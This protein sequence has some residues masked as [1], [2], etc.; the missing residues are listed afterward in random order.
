[1]QKY[2]DLN[3][4]VSVR[5]AFERNTKKKVLFNLHKI[6]SI[7]APCTNCNCLINTHKVCKAITLQGKI[8]FDLVK[9]GVQNIRNSIRAEQDAPQSGSRSV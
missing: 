1:M 7:T 5:K 4:S 6:V 8:P 9:K 2:Y 3:S